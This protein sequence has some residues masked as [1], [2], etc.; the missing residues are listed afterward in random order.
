MSWLDDMAWITFLQNNEPQNVRGKA[1]GTDAAQLNEHE[2]MIDTCFTYDIGMYETAVCVDGEWIVMERY[3]REY[4]AVAGHK[5]WL[6]IARSQGRLEFHDPQ[7]N[8]DRVVE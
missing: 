4:E 5:K 2:I 1:I 8:E 3:L 7:M 6:A